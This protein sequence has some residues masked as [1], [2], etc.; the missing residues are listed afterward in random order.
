MAKTTPETILLKG[1]P[2][3]NEKEAGGAITPGHLLEFSGSNVVVHATA[4]GKAA[5]R[6]A[7]END[8]GGDDIDHAYA[9]GEVVLYMECPPGT[10]VLALLADG[11]NASV[12][13]YLESAANGELRVVDADTSAGTIVVGSI[14]AQAI[15]ALDLSDSAADPT[16]EQRIKVVIV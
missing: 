12:G 9:S 13:S 8:I 6:F 2:I 5:A 4:G 11:E 7:R 10:E 3:Y 14:I 1:D 16:S 15:Q